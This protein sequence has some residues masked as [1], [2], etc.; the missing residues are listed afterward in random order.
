MGFW[1][2]VQEAAGS[3][4]SI[5][6]QPR[7]RA[8]VVAA[9]AQEEGLPQN[10]RL[11][12]GSMKSV[13]SYRGTRKGAAPFCLL[14]STAFL[15]IGALQP[16]LG[17][18]TFKPKRLLCAGTISRHLPDPPT[19]GIP[20]HLLG[21]PFIGRRLCAGPVPEL[22]RFSLPDPHNGP[23]TREGRVLSSPFSRQRNQLG[24]PGRGGGWWV[25][26]GSVCSL[27]GSHKAAV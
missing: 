4:D 18:R 14:R 19:A 16:P 6:K 12:L 21:T 8:A 5:E 9:F 24:L 26:G 17:C 10:R 22:L 3:A 27:G 20:C 25:V 7:A 15:G 1:E 23:R 13:C 11:G 2:Q